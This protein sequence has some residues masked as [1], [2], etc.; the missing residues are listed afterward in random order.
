MPTA[1]ADEYP[2]GVPVRQVNGVD[3]GVNSS[4]TFPTEE[5]LLKRY[6]REGREVVPQNSSQVL[7]PRCVGP[8]AGTIARAHLRD[9]AAAP[10]K[11]Q[12]LFKVTAKG[13]G[14]HLPTAALKEPAQRRTSP[15]APDDVFWPMLGEQVPPLQAPKCKCVRREK[16]ANFWALFARSAQETRSRNEGRDPYAGSRDC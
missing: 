15:E 7:V 16:R 1:K 13:T 12:G 8:K 4:V 14:T 2:G 11:P 10:H 6:R 3:V 9:I 5:G